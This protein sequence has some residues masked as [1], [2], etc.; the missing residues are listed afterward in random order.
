MPENTNNN[1]IEP[2]RS[3]EPGLDVRTPLTVS[4]DVSEDKRANRSLRVIAEGTAAATGEEFFRSLAR[5]AAQALGARYAFV[6]ETLSEMESR[7]L[8]F[9]DVRI[10]AWVHIS[11][12]GH[13]LP[14][15]CGG[16]HLRLIGSRNCPASAQSTRI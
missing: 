7:S 4:G 10:L 5:C 16:S 6:A 9:W 3:T 1:D 2:T 12:S 8:A 14:A 11:F 13:A 15:G